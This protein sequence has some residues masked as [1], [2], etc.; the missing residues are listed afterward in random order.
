MLSVVPN[1]FVTS[2]QQGVGNRF[3]LRRTD[4]S[5]NNPDNEVVACTIP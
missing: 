2:C 3:S 4:L 5:E 1:A